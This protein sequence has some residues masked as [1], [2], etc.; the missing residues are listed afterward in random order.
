MKKNTI[1]LM[2]LATSL[3]TLASCNRSEKLL[4]EKLS[5]RGKDIENYSYVQDA[6]VK[7]LREGDYGTTPTYEG[8]IKRLYVNGLVV[9]MGKLSIASGNELLELLGPLH[10]T[11][12]PELVLSI[13]KTNEETE[14]NIG[15][16]EEE[17]EEILEACAHTMAITNKSKQEV[18]GDMK[19]MSATLPYW[20]NFK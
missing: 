20:K 14:K 9:T 10:Q 15:I 11:R 12:Y 6:H 2:I 16:W 8:C 7:A 18:E 3:T 13:R 4:R 19:K 1:F 17:D 5:N